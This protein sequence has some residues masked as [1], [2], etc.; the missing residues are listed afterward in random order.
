ME[1]LVNLRGVPADEAWDIRELLDSQDIE[2]YETDAGNW[3]IAQPGLWLCDPAQLPAAQVLLAEYWENRRWQMREL[4]A[5]ES[6]DGKQTRALQ[7]FLRAPMRFVAAI[8][9]IALVVYFSVKPF[10]AFLPG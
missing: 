5:Q 3:G 7:T 6:R 1:M 2:Y 10:L 9:V 4:Q 8:G